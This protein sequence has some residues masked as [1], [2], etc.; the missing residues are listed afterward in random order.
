M[1]PVIDLFA[2][3]GGLGEGFSALRGPNHDAVF[4]IVLSIEKDP[5]AHETLKLRSF[6]RQFPKPGV[7]EEYYDHLRGKLS[8]KELYDRFPQE[9]ERAAFEA[10]NAE[11]GDYRKV[12]AATIDERISQALSGASHWVL[13]GGPPCQV[14]SVAGRSRVIPVDP[15]KY[16][17]DRRHFLYKAYLRII[18]EHRPPL[19]VME[20]VRGILTSEV[21]GR[22][23]IDRL[24]NDLQ[25]PIPAAKGET[26]NQNGGL[27]Y[28]IYSLAN[29]SRDPDGLDTEGHTDPAKFIIRSEQ[30]RI[31]QARH[32]FILLGVRSDISERPGFLRNCQESITMWSAI[33]DLPRLRSRLSSGI[34][35]GGVWVEAIRELIGM[36]ALFNG[37]IDDK[38]FFAISSKLDRLSSTMGTGDAFVEWS[39]QPRFRKDW[40]YDPRIGGICNHVSRS[41][42]KSDLWRYFFAA[43]YAAAHKRSPKLPDFPA[44]LL[45]KHENVIG[46]DEKDMIFKDRFRVQLRGKPATTITCHIGKDGHYFIH[47][48]PVQCRSLTVREA[49]RLQT[50]PDNYFFAGPITAQYQQVGNAVPPL[51]ARQLAEI[52]SRLLEKVG[53]KNGSD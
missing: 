22:P 31:P 15:H 25:C 16:E 33:E 42:M 2:G 51:L 23:I 53:R 29:Y 9:A 48:D 28:K 49:A 13:I 30:H 1:I 8:R 39:E 47:P 32:R 45:P 6:F 3:P 14:F 12:R 27:E 46:A 10:W 52:V 4:R 19:F 35:S 7:P 34:D 17:K 43:C 24:L 26:G 50:F 40:F 38:V 44:A 41:H 20:N 5:I 11:L 36:K 21:G 18:A 37:D